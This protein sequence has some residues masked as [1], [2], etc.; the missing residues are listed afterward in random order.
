[1]SFDFDV[2]VI[3]S[4]FGGSVMTLRL[5]EKGHRVCLL[6][7]GRRYGMHE[8]PR[9]MNEFREGVFW[10]PDD[11]KYGFM[12]FDAYPKSDAF[13]V[14]ASGL[15]GGSLIYANVLYR[16]PADFFA[17]W[18]SGITR[19]ELDPYYDRVEHTMEASP[20]PFETDPY[21]RDTPKAHWMKQVSAKLADASDTLVPHQFHFPKL[22]VRFEGDFPGHQTVNSHG[23]IQSKCNKCGE[24]DIGCNIHAKNTLDLNYIA[25]ACNPSLLGPKGKAAEVRT[26]ADVESIVPANGGYTITYVNPVSR[27]EQTTISAHRV[28]VS[29][30]SIGSTTLLLKMRKYGKLTQ[31]SPALG[32]GWCGNGDL[33]G[34]ALKTDHDI[35]PTNGPVI[36]TAIEYRFQ[37]YPDGFAHGM[38]IQDAGFPSFISW[39]VIGRFASASAFMRVIK[40]MVRGVVRVFNR[41][42]SLTGLHRFRREINI[43]DDIAYFIDRDDFV[44][45][46]HLLL[47]MGRDRNDGHIELTDDDQPLIRWRMKN[48]KLH[49]DRVR[50]EMRKIADGLGGTFLDNPL[51]YMNKM[52]AVHPLGGCPMS[53]SADTGV[54]DGNGEAYGHPGLYVV[55]A[56][57][58][59]TS[60]GPNPSLTI[61]AMAERIADRFPSP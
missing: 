29:A 53:D 56:S 48:S 16:M 44:R 1:M 43:S 49:Y 14:R 18:P 21:Y 8:F 38:V 28:I 39:F 9:R 30:G 46:S 23:V 36:T 3:G 32:K 34:T 60:V 12:E 33:E 17:G 40:F 47:G 15:G 19:T 58:L 61:A 51:T 26:L 27:G 7:R 37:P 52:I 57:I 25:Q 31:L 13:S 10:D 59:P 42:L 2:I 24:C 5:A 22:A 20:Y 11:A 55:D 6:E 35:V 45:K 54:V 41:L 50:R 4:G